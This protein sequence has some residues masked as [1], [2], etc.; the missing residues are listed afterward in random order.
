MDYALINNVIQ[1]HTPLTMRIQSYPYQINLIQS[2]NYA[3]NTKTL[4]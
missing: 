4:A 1:T 3:Y 2:V